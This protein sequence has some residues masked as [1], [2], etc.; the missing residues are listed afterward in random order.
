MKNE[1]NLLES[2]KDL[3]QENSEKLTTRNR[4]L[5]NKLVALRA[6][7]DLTRSTNNA[8]DEDLEKLLQVKNKTK[9]LTFFSYVVETKTHCVLLFKYILYHNFNNRYRIIFSGQNN[10]INF[11]VLISLRIPF[12]NVFF[13]CLS[14]FIMQQ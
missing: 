5:E 13:Y 4:E 12:C 1:L 10:K 14:V 2:N 9:K 8:N 11:L 3:L 7:L 6:E